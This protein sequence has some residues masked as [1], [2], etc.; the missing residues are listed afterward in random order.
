M[1]GRRVKRPLALVILD[2]W[3]LN[4]ECDNNAVCQA[5]K[6]V[7]D[8]LFRRYPSTRL[9]T[10][11]LA[12]GLPEGQMGNSEVGHLNIGAGRIVYQD[13]TRISKSISDG[14]FFQNP[15]LQQVL[16]KVK[17]RGG[18]LH[19]MGL[20]SDGGV[21]SH[22]THLYALVQMAKTVGLTQVCIHAF[23]DGRDTPPKSGAGYLLDL[24]KE[25]ATLGIGR[26][27]TICGRFYAMDR[28]N[29]WDRVEKAYRALTLG[30]GK[31]S[32]SSAAAI[33]EAYAA[34]QTDEFVEP[35]VI[36]PNGQTA[37]TVDPDDGIIFF[38][39]RAD[40]AREITRAFTDTGFSGFTRTK[41][42]ALSDFVCMTEYDETFELPVAFPPES[43]ANLLG[44]VVSHA[45]LTQ[46]R[47]A[48]TEKYAHVTFFFNGG[49]EKP[50]QGEDRVLIPS[51]Q[52][53]ATYDLKPAMSAP[54]VTDEVV[55]RVMSGKYDFIVLNFANPDM[56]GHTGNLEAAT[57]AMETVDACL[58]RVVE[59]VLRAGGCLLITADHGNCEQ[60]TDRSGHPHTA[61]TANPVPLLLVDPDL[62]GAT[63]REGILAD[64][65]PTIL[66]LLQLE[67]P[68]EMTGKNLLMPQ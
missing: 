1:A 48:E 2:G 38:N 41:S 62:S 24:E 40:R 17:H 18:K 49:S 11:G 51:P 60:M 14:D 23:L 31:C 59:T 45:G 66:S 55:D 3:G 5:K 47:I 39:F 64:L 9:T 42:P 67:K 32:K 30:E 37:C 58:G 16:E 15:V 26:V 25:L 28:D 29:R 21:H 10:S 56:V 54:A 44:E 53:V 46:L 27:A 19:L 6:P 7:L 34:G 4:D 13:F 43:Y 68:D 35:R 61:H 36:V 57:T 22:N 52:D 65:A 12:V 63:L 50:F 20:L 33:E 8:G